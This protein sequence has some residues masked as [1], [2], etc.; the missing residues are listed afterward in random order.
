MSFQ[1][2]S[3]LIP[4][5]I[6]AFITF[7]LSIYSYKYRNVKGAKAFLLSMLTGS[8]WALANGLEMAG[9][10]LE[11]KIFWANIQYFFYAFAPLIWLIMV[12]EFTD[13]EKL[14][15][16]KNI[17][18][19]S[20][21]P[22]LTI[23]LVWTNSYHNL[24]RTNIS[25]DSSGIFSV[26]VKDYGLWFWVH[27]I[28]VYILNVLS[29][30]FLVK[31]IWNSNNIYKNQTLFIFLGYTLIFISNF[32]YVI[33]YNPITRFDISPVLFSI[34][35]LLMGWGIFRYK[36]F[37]IVPIARTT[38]IE[39]MASG[40]VVVD[41]KK[42]IIDIN[43]RI[44]DMFFLNK[45]NN[46]LG[47]SLN[48]ISD[49]LDTIFESISFESNEGFINKELTYEY[50]NNTYYY[51]IFMSFIDDS[52]NN[53]L[54]GVMIIHDITDLKKA[55]EKITKQQK[56]LAVMNER[57][58]MARDLHDNLG[59]VLSFSTVQIQAAR[60]Q[61]KKENITLADQYLERLKKIIRDAHKDIR[62]YVYN[63]RSNNKYS[64]DFMSLLKN[65]IKH[66][67][68]KSDIEIE[69]KNYLNN[70]D[71]VLNVSGVEEKIQLINIVKEA[72]TNVLKHGEASKVNII[73]KHHNDGFKLVIEDDGRGIGNLNENTGSG[74]NIMNERARL[75]GG[76][77]NIE[78]Q[79]GAGCKIIVD[80][81]IG[82]E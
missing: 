73:S 26:I 80:L 32:L 49:Q 25:L 17:F 11:T 29:I 82:G 67:K 12:F 58:R 21:I 66:F 31:A 71:E 72:L 3:Y 39:E 74:F 6:S 40:I 54:A 55:R 56:E 41:K 70:N 9:V 44:K 51:E 10:D 23:I 19:L 37:D 53:L 24:M 42:R 1:Y 34:S 47:E 76:T 43:P 13:R 59:Q 78:S 33:G 16:K 5:F 38:I 20:I 65:E 64:K 2:T 28:Y 46:Y 75:I 61:F 50:N 15:N 52:K 62:E 60:Q 8:L 48:V 45:N 36:I 14:V 77:L 63:V 22:I 27:F 18:L 30:L 69:H 35:G 7:L 57:Q 79:P 4:L 68:Q 81:P